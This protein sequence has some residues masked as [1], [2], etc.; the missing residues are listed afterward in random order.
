MEGYEDKGFIPVVMLGKSYG[1]GRHE[2]SG[3]INMGKKEK[4]HEDIW[5]LDA[6]IGHNRM[7]IL[8]FG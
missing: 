5:Y 3:R 8:I 4:Y 7:G 1:C 6:H 2:F